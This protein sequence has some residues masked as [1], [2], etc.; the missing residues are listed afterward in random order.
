MGVMGHYVGDSSQPLHTSK[1]HN[2]WVGENPLGYPTN[3][4]FH[5]WIDG[6]YFHKIGGLKT[7]ALAQRIKPAE[8]VGDSAQPDSFFQ[9]VVAHVVKQ[10]KQVEP[11][12]KLE[13]EHKLSPRSGEIDP[14]GLAFMEG[15]ILQGAQMLGNIW[16]SAWQDATEDKHL[17]TELEKRSKAESAAKENTQRQGAEK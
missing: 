17:K 2:G 1:H 6:G 9:A 7:E 5:A 14:E 11:L 16:L 10:N 4:T 13:K 15:Q 3:R 12:Y 8:H